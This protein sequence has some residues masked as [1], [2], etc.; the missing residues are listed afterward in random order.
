MKTIQEQI[1]SLPR[2]KKQI[3]EV[4][5]YLIKRHSIN[6]RQMML[7][8]GV[9][10]L[11]ARIADLRNKHFLNIDCNYISV[12]NKFKRKIEFGYWSVTDKQKALNIYKKLQNK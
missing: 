8:T 7:D 5:Y 1:N 3:E 10:N 9:L 12:K 2:P 11:T 4:L 6:G